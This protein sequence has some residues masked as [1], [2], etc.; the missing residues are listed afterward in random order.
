M[1]AKF[2]APVI[3]TDGPGLL[4]GQAPDGR[5]LCSRRI[6]NPDG[7][8]YRPAYRLY[9]PDEVT[10]VLSQPVTDHRKAQDERNDGSG[11]PDNAH[12]RSA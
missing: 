8:T 6:V 11:T 5:L 4:F 3:T 2:L 1:N 10:T 9:K 12:H 7:K